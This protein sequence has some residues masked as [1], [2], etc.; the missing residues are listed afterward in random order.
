MVDDAGNVLLDSLV[1]PDR[2]TEW[3]EAQAIHGITPADVMNAPSLESLL[4]RLLAVIEDAG[5]LVIYNAGFDLAFG[6]RMD[7]CFF[8]V[9]DD[10]HCP[11][12]PRSGAARL[13]G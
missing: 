2:H 5:T 8:L 3:P 6:G 9:D 1:K 13:R 7:P 11:D 12:G 10:F 4:P